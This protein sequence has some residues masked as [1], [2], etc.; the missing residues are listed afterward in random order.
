M[1]A[2]VI[3]V[4]ICHRAPPVTPLS[5]CENGALLRLSRPRVTVAYLSGHHLPGQAANLSGIPHLPGID[6]HW[7]TLDL[8]LWHMGEGR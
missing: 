2:M 3:V 4:I 8:G 7:T 6:W 1:P 5:K